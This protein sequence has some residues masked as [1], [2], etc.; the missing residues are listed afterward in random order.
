[1]QLCK[2]VD[3]QKLSE[4][5]QK[6]CS[7]EPE[8]HPGATFK[9]LKI[10]ATLKLFTTGSITLTAP[11]V[12]VAKEAINQ[13]YPILLEFKRTFP[14]EQMQQ[15]LNNNISNQMISKIESNFTTQILQQQ[16]GFQGNSYNK[17]TCTIKA[18]LHDY[19]PPVQ[20]TFSNFSFYSNVS[21]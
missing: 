13:I 20:S 9:L 3:I 14:A 10:K 1:M 18:E 11:S 15:H 6:E 16:K 7:Y 5:Y 17:N 19:K 2:G 12:L 21:D 8:L 4:N